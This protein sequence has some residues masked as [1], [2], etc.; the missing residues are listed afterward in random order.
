MRKAVL[1][2]LLASFAFVVLAPA[3]A[4]AQSRSDP[5]GFHAGLY[6][7]GSA[8]TYEGSD[9]AES[10]G[11][12]GLTLGW[13]LTNLVTLY[14]EGSGAQVETLDGS[15]TYTLGHFDV[16]AR[17]NFLAPY[18]RWR[19]FA[20]VGLSGRAAEGDVGGAIVTLSGTGLTVGGGVAYFIS[21]KIAVDLGLKWTA[22]DF[23]D[24]E[25]NDVA[26]D[27]DPIGATSARFDL[28]VAYWHGRR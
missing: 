16:G 11:G 1:A 19:P 5:T 27:I 18:K 3:H 15:D 21:R 13:G 8:I 23:T 6:L 26:V 24:A 22:G 28:G 25:L 14:L 7:N 4:S 17:V 12:Y 2:A 10:G 9:E 20:T